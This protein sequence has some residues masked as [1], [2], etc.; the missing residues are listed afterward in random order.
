VTDAAGESA[1]ASAPVSVQNVAPVITSLTASAS[2]VRVG[3]ALTLTVAF[4]DAGTLDTHQA[5]VNWG[6]GCPETVVT[7]GGYSRTASHTYSAQGFFTPVVTVT[8]KDG[9]AASASAGE[10]VVYDAASGASI[11]GN[12]WVQLPAG[13]VAAN[14]GLS[15]RASFSA[16]AGYSTA[17]AAGGSVWFGLGNYTVASTSVDWLIVS[18]N[19]AYYQGQATLNGSAGY[20]FRFTGLDGKLASIPHQMRLQVWSVAT[21]AIVI[22]TA[23]IQNPNGSLQTLGGGNIT[24]RPRSGS[25]TAAFSTTVPTGKKAKKK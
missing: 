15:G 2:T 6:D 7:G 17:G 13:T 23:G 24:V 19:T 25:D 16:D 9:S 12:G 10:I 8:D 21:G 5:R 11:K 4:G 18:G 14:P 20:R 3:A 1:T 22:D